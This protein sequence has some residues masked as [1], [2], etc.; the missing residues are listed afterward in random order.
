MSKTDNDIS[1]LVSDLLETPRAVS[2]DKAPNLKKIVIPGNLLEDDIDDIENKGHQATAGR[3]VIIGN[4]NVIHNY[5]EETK[6]NY[7]RDISAMAINRDVINYRNIGESVDIHHMTRNE[8]ISYL[9]YAYQITNIHKWDGVERLHHRPNW[10]A[11]FSHNIKSYEEA[12]EFIGIE[13]NNSAPDGLEKRHIERRQGIKDIRTY[14]NNRRVITEKGRRKED[15]FNYLV[16][17]STVIVLLV[18]II[19]WIAYSVKEFI[20]G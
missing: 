20:Y 1:K 10:T 13:K 4:N 5:I 9:G 14:K 19:S 18:I 6:V 15:R 12:L 7:T 8:Y 16:Y 3:D 17:F 11:D 2:D